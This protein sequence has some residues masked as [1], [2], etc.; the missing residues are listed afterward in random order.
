[1]G[2]YLR[3]AGVTVSVLISATFAASAPAAAGPPAGVRLNLE[4]LVLT[5]G[6]PTTAAIVDH[7]SAEGVPFHTVDLTAADRPVIDAAFLSDTIGEGDDAVTRGR[8][9]AVVMPNANP[10]GNATELAAVADYERT[11]GVRQIDAYVWPDASVGL[12]A[13]TYAGPL[14][15]ITGTV[16]PAG[17]AGAFGYLRGPVPFEDIAPGLDESYGFLAQP[18]P[19]ATFTPLLTSTAPNGTTGN[20]LMGE[21]TADG[22]EHLVMTFSYNAEQQQFRLLAPGMVAWATGG[23]HLGQH[24]NFFAVHVDDVLLPDSRWSVA[25]NCT[26]GED[27][28][29]AVTTP[30]IRMTPDDVS[31]AVTWQ[32]QKQFTLDMVYNAGGS[33][34]AVGDQPGGADPLTD[35]LL[36]QRSQ[37]RWTNHTLT[38]EWLGCLRATFIAPW[39]CE[40]DPDGSG[41]WTGQAT[42]NGEIADNT[43]WGTAHDLPLDRSELVSGE[44]SGLKLTPQQP[45]HNPNLA[46][47]LAANGITWV[48]ADN[49]RMPDQVAIGAAR[50]VPR[51]PLN[52]FFNVAT[53]AEQ[54][55][56]YNWIYN[57]RADGGSGVCDDNPATVTCV[58]PLDPQTGYTGY[59]VP[60][61]KRLT[62]SRILGNDPRPHFVHQSNLTEDR[63][64]YPLLDSVLDGY[65][66]LIADNS[67]IVNSRMSANG[68]ELQRQSAWAA[69]VK[70]GTASAYLQDGR[71]VVTAPAGVHVPLTVP[72]GSH[73]T[74]PAGPVFGEAYAGARSAWTP[75]G[76][77]GTVTVTLP[78]FVPGPA[79][80]PT[81]S[82]EPTVE[83]SAEPSAEPTP[84]EEP[85]AEPGTDPT[86]GPTTEPTEGPTPEPSAE[87]TPEEPP[88]D[89]S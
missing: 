18:A 45:A 46:P 22:R 39:T 42:I 36:A 15:A 5:D 71:V 3:F 50:T 9:Q 44:H 77:D 66:S 51:Y 78:G 31:H 27:C 1:M 74:G 52:V 17:A 73:L 16:T 32:T 79:V 30:D 19:G 10:F 49:S 83:P 7:L 72:E 69:A 33:I 70:A 25:G 59:I 54:V 85:S 6:G 80:E 53:Q 37:F 57:S 89:Q 21:F 76:A 28:P 12:S 20:V 24:R 35:A 61:E 67:P 34:E 41:R 47:A 4:V 14:D 38:H 11:F 63:L 26:P 48:A 58:P 8:Y 84:T 23:V 81:P 56:E 88:A 68:L 60:L 13:P 62:L 75:V 65:R 2:R 82:T 87:P 86:P 29:S 43:A 64:I 40:T 55:D